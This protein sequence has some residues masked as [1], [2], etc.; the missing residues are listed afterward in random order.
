MAMTKQ[1]IMDKVALHLITQG[2]ASMSYGGGSC[3]YRGQDGKTCAIGCL[4]EDAAYSGEMEGDTP[5]HGNL[6]RYA[7]VMSGVIDETTDAAMLDYLEELQVA[8]DQCRHYKGDEWA[9]VVSKEL[10]QLCHQHT[11]SV[12]LCIAEHYE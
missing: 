2:E 6:V 7:L 11:L 9:R 10:I 1:A 5:T 8:H 4:I 12:P 3:L